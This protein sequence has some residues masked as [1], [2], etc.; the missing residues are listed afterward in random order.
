M[1]LNRTRFF[2]LLL[3]IIASPFL[4]YN[5]IWLAI[6]VKTNGLVRFHGKAY[7]GQLVNEYSVISF[8]DGKDTIWFNSSDGVMLKKGLHVTVY[9]MPNNPT[10]ARVGIFSEIWGPIIGFSSVPLLVL[11]LAFIHP[12]LVPR[13]AKFSLNAKKPFVKAIPVK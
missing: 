10:N 11:L 12:N 3:C 6:S 7:S 4:L 5:F 2:L 9:Y 1:I 8:S 13:H